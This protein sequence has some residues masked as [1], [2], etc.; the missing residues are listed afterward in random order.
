[1]PAASAA[2][3]RARTHAFAHFAKLVSL[4]EWS[5]AR[6]QVVN[7]ELVG[8]ILHPL[9]HGLPTLPLD[10]AAAAPG[11]SATLPPP[12]H[13]VVLGLLV[14]T[15]LIHSSRI[16]GRELWRAAAGVPGLLP[17]G[18]TYGALALI[19]RSQFCTRCGC[20]RS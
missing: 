19:A 6:G 16:H 9:G 1:M 11:F 17:P 7:G 5:W 2:P 10:A 3:A 18:V 13:C 12:F 14:R 15:R 8:V 20:I 4:G